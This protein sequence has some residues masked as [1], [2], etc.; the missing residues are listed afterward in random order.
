MRSERYFK[1]SNDNREQ[2]ALKKR[3]ILRS[4]FFKWP[5]VLLMSVPLIAILS[6]NGMAGPMDGIQ[7]DVYVPFGLQSSTAGNSTSVPQGVSG[8]NVSDAMSFAPASAGGWLSQS[9]AIGTG[10]YT[11]QAYDVLT[12][13][14]GMSGNDTAALDDNDTAINAMSEDIGNVSDEYGTENWY[15]NSG[16]TGFS[17]GTSGISA[18]LGAFKDRLILKFKSMIP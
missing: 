3:S 7:L 10:Q 1:I 14:Q 11:N 13:D 15:S 8:M 17:P 18:N 2:Q 5:I 6:M 9:P 16:Q 4:S 12:E